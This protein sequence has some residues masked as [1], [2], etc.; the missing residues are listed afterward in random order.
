MFGRIVISRDVYVQADD[1][2]ELLNI[3]CYAAQDGFQQLG[4][5][6]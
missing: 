6:V 5:F 4:H 1:D 3:N 2:C